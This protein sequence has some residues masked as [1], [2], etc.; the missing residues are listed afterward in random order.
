MGK[1]AVVGSINADMILAVERLPLPGETVLGGKFATAGGGKGANQ[2][3]AA[4]RAGAEVTFIAR[5][6]DDGL[7]REAIARFAEEGI[8]TA[9]IVLDEEAPTGV[10]LIFVDTQGENCIG[11]ASG[12][13]ARLS[14]TDIDRAR[15][16]IA[17]ADILLMQL[18]IPIE[19][20]TRAAEVATAHDVPVILNPAPACA[21]PDGLLQHVTIITPNAGEAGILT[22]LTVDDETALAQAARDLQKRGPQTVLIT[23]GAQGLCYTLDG[24]MSRVPCHAVTAVD[25]TAAGDAFNGALAAA[26]AESRPF[27]GAVEFANAAAALSVQRP[28]AQPSLPR[29]EAIE[30]MQQ[31][32]NTRA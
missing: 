7:G 23:L 5:A 19:T 10:A 1:V 32:N 27:Q 14:P 29:R 26:L 17:G 6:G 16:D 8:N 12:A 2:A 11:V 24:E 4:A 9:N 3:V 31:G 13:N 30:T 28:G 20:V 15:E 18:E 21:L 25:T 22:G